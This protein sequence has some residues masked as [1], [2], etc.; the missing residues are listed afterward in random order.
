MLTNEPQGPLGS[1]LGEEPHKQ[2]F[3]SRVHIPN[4]RG[5]KSRVWIQGAFKGLGREALGGAR[6]GV[7]DGLWGGV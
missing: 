1:V 2:S 6:G 3:D 4:Y 5:H 7:R